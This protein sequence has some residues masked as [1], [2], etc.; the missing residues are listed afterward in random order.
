V[1]AA[2]HVPGTVNVPAVEN[3]FSTWAGWYVDYAAPTYLIAEEA[4]LPHIL[5]EL[6][7]IGVDNIPGYFPTDVLP[8]NGGTVRQISPKDASRL[9]KEQGAYLLD[10][11]GTD[12]YR[13]RHIPRSHHIP[14]GLVPDHVGELPRQTPIIVQCGSGFRSHVVAS[15]LQ[16]RGFT[17][18]HNLTG[19]IDAWESAGLPL[20]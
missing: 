8:K 9:L 7:A 12:E 4:D 16:R 5:S 6:R 17:N 2:N 15:L 13:E 19:G 14:M 10:V 20:E 11:R 18:I 1:F 3:S